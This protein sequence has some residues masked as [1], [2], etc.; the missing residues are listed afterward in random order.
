MDYCYR[1]PSESRLRDGC[2]SHAHCLREMQPCPGPILRKRHSSFHLAAGP[3]WMLLHVAAVGRDRSSEGL[4]QFKSIMFSFWH[5]R[6]SHYKLNNYKRSSSHFISS[7]CVTLYRIAR[8]GTPGQAGQQTKKYRNSHEAEPR[9]NPSQHVR[10]LTMGRA[11]RLNPRLGS[12]QS[13]QPHITESRTVKWCF[14]SRSGPATRLELVLRGF[15]AK[16]SRSAAQA[17]WQI[18]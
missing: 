7:R 8:Q 5:R 17:K 6:S 13:H 16:S 10:L 18:H 4:G 9:G 12:G 15:I 11:T 14:L 3:R 1:G 2:S